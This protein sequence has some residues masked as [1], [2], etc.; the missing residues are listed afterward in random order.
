M[1]GGTL[2][3]FYSNVAGAVL[4]IYYV[5]GFQRNCRDSKAGFVRSAYSPVC[6]SDHHRPCNNF[7]CTFAPWESLSAFSVASNAVA[8]IFQGGWYATTRHAISGLA[9]CSLT[10]GER[11]LLQWPHVFPVQ[12]RERYIFMLDLAEGTVCVEFVLKL[13]S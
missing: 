8:V 6:A 10:R 13:V 7:I 4:G 1:I 5:W 3:L 2:R 12:H 11:A 9:I